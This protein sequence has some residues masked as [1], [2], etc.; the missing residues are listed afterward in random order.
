MRRL[1][2]AL[3]TLLMIS[4]LTACGNSDAQVLV[5][6]SVS[7]LLEEATKQEEA[8]EDVEETESEVV[9]YEE[10]DISTMFGDDD[11]EKESTTVESEV[12]TEQAQGTT[13]ADS[14]VDVDLTILSTTMLYGEIYN[15]AIN[16]TPYLESTIKVTG[17]YGFYEDTI[18]DI[19]Y[20]SVIIMD[21]TGCCA[22]G[23]EFILADDYTYP[24]D[25]P[26]IG[27]EITIIGELETY[28]EIGYTFMRLKN[29]TM[30][31]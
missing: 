9:E 23:F 27:T 16:P 18:N 19:K 10:L 6:G 29:A 1:C 14:E 17:S 3:T 21:S 30:E 12:S 11:E 4:A 28:E 7:Y 26:E 13:V 2:Y 15:I 5:E 8:V 31:Y 24:D 22:Q 25:Y 20:F